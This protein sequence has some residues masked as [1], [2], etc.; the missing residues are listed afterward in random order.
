MI[1]IVDQ[2]PDSGALVAEP[3]MLNLALLLPRPDKRRVGCLPGLSQALGLDQKQF[4]FSKSKKGFRTERIRTLAE[5]GFRFFPPVVE[6]SASCGI[7]RESISDATGLSPLITRRNS[8]KDR[9]SRRFQC[10]FAD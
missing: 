1:L 5:H 3:I 2:G 4:A 6:Q 7:V 8:V 9:L 10:R